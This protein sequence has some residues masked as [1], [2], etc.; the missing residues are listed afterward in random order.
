MNAVTRTD[1]P[2]TVRMDVAAIVA[3]FHNDNTDRL[4]WEALALLDIPEGW[5]LTGDTD[6]LLVED[7]VIDVCVDLGKGTAFLV[8]DEA[9]RTISVV[10]K[11]AIT[12]VYE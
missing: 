11:D 6:L 4:A 12:A 10:S 3:D 8:L 9:A 2:H 1:Q 7:E 5:N